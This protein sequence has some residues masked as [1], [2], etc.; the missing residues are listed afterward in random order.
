MQSGI[1]AC[2][3]ACMLLLPGH[4]MAQVPSQIDPGLQRQRIQDM[5][6]QRAV[7]ERARQVEVPALQGEAG[8]MAVQIDQDAVFVVQTIQFSPSRFLDAAEL[9]ALARPYVGRGIRFADLNELLAQINALY[10]RAGQVT[11]RAIIPPQALNDGLLKILLVEARVDEVTWEG[12]PRRVDP[13]FYDRRLG[14]EQGA[15]LDAPALMADIQRLN[16]TTPGPQVSASLAPGQTF[17]TTRVNLQAFEPERLQWMAFANN[18]GNVGSGRTQ[19]GGTFVWFSPTGAA[20]SLTALAVLSADSRF[21]S[22]RY[23]RPVNRYNGVV[24]VEAGANTMEITEGPYSDLNIEGDSQ[25]YS[26]GYDHPWWINPKWLLRGGVGYVQQGS[27]TTIEGLPLSDTDIGEFTLK[28]TAEYRSAP[29]YIRYDQRIRQASTD[30]RISGESG[31]YVLFNG[32]GYLS[33]VF[34]ER[35]ELVGRL[36]WQRSNDAESLPS[37]LYFQF[38]GVG[39][40]RGYDPGV[41]ASPHGIAVNL[42]GYWHLNER[43]QT[44]L[45]YDY[46]KATELG[47]RDVT[48]QSAGAGV[49][50]IW[51]K[52]FSVNLLV[53]STMEDV[54]PD[55]DGSQILLQLQAR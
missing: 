32:A 41:I 2:A 3:L 31:N 16:A 52:R 45:F 25:I 8:T 28:G 47:T 26:A 15:V 29:W 34:G 48:L 14:I 4:V 55:Q 19:Y 54:V 18:H 5:E 49:N 6:R 23:S 11:A 1:S 51:S 44:F 21:G 33:R 35:Y 39:V 53:A 24:N 13:S 43:W 10:E 7:E 17:G 27:E 20:D 12:E 37:A 30:N 36:A 42:E 9:E 46:G 22:L 50:F 38:G 40:S